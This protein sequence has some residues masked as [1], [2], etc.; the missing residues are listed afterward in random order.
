MESIELTKIA[1]GWTS[2]IYQLDKTKVVKIIDKGA[3]QAHFDREMTAY[4]RMSE[5]K[6]RPSSI[7]E[8]FGAYDKID[9][10]IILSFAGGGNLNGYLW[11][12]LQAK[13]RPEKTLLNRWAQQLAEAMSFVHSCD[14]IHCDIHVANCFLDEAENLKLGDFG[15]CKIDGGLSLMSYR[16]THQLWRWDK[17]SERW[18]K[19]LS[20]NSEIFAYGCTLFFMETC[21][22]PFDGVD[23]DRDQEEIARKLQ[24]K[25]MP[26]L[27]D[28]PVFRDTI[29]KCWDLQYSSMMVII[30]D[31]GR[32]ASRISDVEDAV[33][34]E[35]GNTSAPT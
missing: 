7:L 2:S 31:I 11:D 21:K 9:R 32:V 35:K 34:L 23:H 27:D 6:P 15:A 3:Q 14:I 13:E 33:V 16:R 28:I 4:Q 29:R 20:V 8:F 19:D 17:S 25:E 24:N 26:P 22:E 12:C 10:G 1:W 30:K 5:H 18:R